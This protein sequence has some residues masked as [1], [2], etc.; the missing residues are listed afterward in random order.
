MLDLTIQLTKSNRLSPA[1]H[2]LAVYNP[3]NGR[4]V[5]FKASQMIGT[6]RID[7]VHLVNKKASRDKSK[8]HTV[9]QPFE[10][11]WELYSNVTEI[12]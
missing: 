1:D 8:R 3:D 7:T 6:L 4:P 11:W 12:I 10:V 2:T 5:D 9:A